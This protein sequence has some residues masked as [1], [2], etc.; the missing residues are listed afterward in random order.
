MIDIEITLEPSFDEFVLN[1]M[2]DG[3]VRSMA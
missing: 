1:A 3:F 2:T